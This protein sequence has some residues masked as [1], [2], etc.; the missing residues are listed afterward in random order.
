MLKKGGGKT[1]PTQL[2]FT[3]TSTQL[4]QLESFVA[5]QTQSRA[6]TT[7]APPVT[8]NKSK[9]SPQRGTNLHLRQPLSAPADALLQ[10]ISGHDI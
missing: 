6:Q 5:H 2:A 4:P 8:L 3:L 1:T 10:R 7:P 9:I